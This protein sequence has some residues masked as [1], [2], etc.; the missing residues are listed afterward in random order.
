MIHP[1]RAHE[2]ID[3]HAELRKQ[4]F[5]ACVDPV[6]DVFRTADAAVSGAKTAAEV[7][8]TPPGLLR[9]LMTP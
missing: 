5:S 6:L 3:L 7:A 9:H 8:R 4:A 2:L 1:A